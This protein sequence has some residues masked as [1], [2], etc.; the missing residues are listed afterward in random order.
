MPHEKFNTC[1]E[2]CADICQSC[3]DEC[4]KHKHDHCQECAK[5]CKRCTEECRKMA[6]MA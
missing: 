5:A 6:A 1:I 2:A 4:E 3:G